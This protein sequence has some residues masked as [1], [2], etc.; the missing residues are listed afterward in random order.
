MSTRASSRVYNQA[1]LEAW[2]E[3]VANDWE[4][5]F[6][7]DALRQGREIYRNSEISGIELSEKDAIVHC[8]F[9]RKDT[10]YVVLE[11]DAWELAFEGDPDLN[12]YRNRRFQPRALLLGREEC[13]HIYR[14]YRVN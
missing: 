6:S 8:S 14:Y 7:R 3:H 9:T 5:A 4:S 13:P 1:A 2:F 12:V 10:C 11:W